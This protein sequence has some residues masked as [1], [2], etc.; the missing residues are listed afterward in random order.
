[1]R[2][3]LLA[4]AA[5]CVVFIAQSCGSQAQVALEMPTP[6]AAPQDASLLTPARVVSVL[7]GA[8][9]EVDLDGVISRVRY[10]GIDVPADDR[11]TS[12]E[13]TVAQQA[14]HFNRFLLDGKTVQLERG[15]VETDLA[16]SLIRYVYVDGEM[17]NK[18]LLTNG[19][20]TVAAYP[21]RFRYQTEFLEAEQNAKTGSRR[22]WSRPGSTTQRPDS[23]PPPKG[24]STP[25][26]P[27]GG[28]TLPSPG[29]GGKCDYSGT[30]QHVIKGNIDR[31]TGALAYHVPGG[32][33]YDSTSVD[34]AQGDQWF[35]LEL[36]AI[37]AGFKRSK[38]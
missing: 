32:L 15:A 8:T 33:F 4:V 27:F 21:P 20:A 2:A 25:V 26:P 17:V 31:R 13:V 34:G 19:Y 12:V 28:G 11:S 3:Y 5:G 6:F 24:S 22:I 29:D 38:R 30:S 35:C 7:D 9:I 14:F 1:M 16:G 36:E 10:L 23:T 37:A 18:E